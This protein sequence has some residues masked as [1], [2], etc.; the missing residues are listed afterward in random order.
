MDLLRKRIA[1]FQTH[2]VRFQH[3]HQQLKR[4]YEQSL[5]HIFDRAAQSEFMEKYS[6]HLDRQQKAIQTM[7]QLYQQSID[8]LTAL[9]S[10][11]N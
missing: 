1:H 3:M 7:A 6:I 10:K 4:F 8:Q 5:P 9:E 11:Q 2:M